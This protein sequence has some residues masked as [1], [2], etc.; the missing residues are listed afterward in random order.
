MGTIQIKEERK[1]FTTIIST[2]L[3]RT[4]NILSY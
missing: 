2:Q 3:D 1:L 4:G